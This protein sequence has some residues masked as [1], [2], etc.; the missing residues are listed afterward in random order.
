[1]WLICVHFTPL[2]LICVHWGSSDFI[3]LNHVRCKGFLVSRLFI[4]GFT[5]LFVFTF[6]FHCFHCFL[7]FNARRSATYSCQSTVVLSNLSR[8]LQLRF[9]CPFN[10]PFNHFCSFLKTKVVSADLSHR[11][12]HSIN[13]KLTRTETLQRSVRVTRC[14][15]FVNTAASLIHMVQH[16]T[17]QLNDIQRKIIGMHGI[18]LVS[19][20]L[21]FRGRD[22]GRPLVTRDCGLL[23]SLTLGNLGVGL[24][25]FWSRGILFRSR[26]HLLRLCLILVNC[27]AGSLLWLWWLNVSSKTRCV[28]FIVFVDLF[29]EC[30]A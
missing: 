3:F 4:S 5:L 9:L 28:I 29:H 18:P 6:C 17:N 8:F 2:R 30:P 23:H 13:V 1:M 24:L 25:W 10:I 20:T 26:W 27:C 14:L 11:L 19:C 12:S 15:A 21:P 16:T 22:N 7:S